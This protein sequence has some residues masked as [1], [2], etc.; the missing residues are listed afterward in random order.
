MAGA[1]LPSCFSETG[2][3]YSHAPALDLLFILW[4]DSGGCP[5]FPSSIF[6]GFPDLFRGRKYGIGKS[7]TAA[8]GIPGFTIF[9]VVQVSLFFTKRRWTTSNTKPLKM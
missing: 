1:C 9:F 3:A 2:A 6:S 8:T 4:I 5:T 7:R